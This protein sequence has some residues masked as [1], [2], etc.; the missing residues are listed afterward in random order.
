MTH[1]AT[2][3]RHRRP[4]TTNLPKLKSFLNLIR[5]SYSLSSPRP[6][7]VLTHVHPPDPS[8]H[9]P[10]L[11]SFTYLVSFCLPSSRNHLLLLESFHLKKKPILSYFFLYL[12]LF[13]SLSLS[14]YPVTRPHTAADATATSCC[15]RFEKL[16][17][18]ENPEQPTHARPCQF[19][20]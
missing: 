7:E 9:P 4:A 8:I 15:A 5:T 2:G 3:T 6:P 14:F 12:S 17:N 10:V 19:R 16:S 11:S 20:G 18:V 13:L 1:R